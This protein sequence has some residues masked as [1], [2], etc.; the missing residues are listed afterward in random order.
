MGTLSCTVLQASNPLSIMKFSLAIASAIMA[1]SAVQAAP[2][3]GNVVA[4]NNGGD[5]KKDSHMPEKYGDDKKY[6]DDMKYDDKKGDDKKYDDKKYDDK[7]DDKKD[8][9]MDG[10][11]PFEFTSTYPVYATPDT[12]ISATDGP[13]PGVEGASG[14]FKFGIN[15]EHDYICYNIELFGYPEGFEYSSPANTA[16]HIHEAPAGQAGPP[17]LAFENPTYRNGKLQSLGC[18]SGPYKTGITTADGSD[19]ADGFT[20]AQI[21]ANPSGFFADNHVA[22]ALAGAVR[23]QLS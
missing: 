21:E 16:T 6:D 8:H 2:A 10:A 9:D 19:T 17:R 1:F 22:A 13:V 5:Y 12:I 20:V 14:T 18:L 7:K 15:S 4:R 23:G 11:F 3:T